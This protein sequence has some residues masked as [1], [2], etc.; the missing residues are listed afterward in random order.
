MAQYRH[1]I[2]F[3]VRTKRQSLLKNEINELIKGV[4][5]YQKEKFIFWEEVVGEKI[6]N[7]AVPVKNKKGVLFVKVEDSVWRFELTRRKDELISKINEHSKK[8]LIKDIV[9]I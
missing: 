3:K 2:D 6:S 1:P 4:K 8:N 5:K 9:F 7:V